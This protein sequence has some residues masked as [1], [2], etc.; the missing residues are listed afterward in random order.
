M[1]LS[2]EWQRRISRIESRNAIMDLIPQ[3]SRVIDEHDLEGI[4]SLFTPEG[5]LRNAGRQMDARGHEGIRALYRQVFTMLGPSFH[6]SHN[7]LIRFDEKD[8]DRATGS[9]T[10]HSET[11]RKGAQYLAA[12]R[13]DDEYR[14]IE[15]RWLFQGRQLNFLYFCTM[16]ELRTILGE[17]KRITVYD[18]PALDGDWPETGEAWRRFSGAS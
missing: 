9:V 15:G 4:V 7:H 12:I 6:Y 11:F 3:Y 2:P 13:Y 17:Q 5:Y 8:E 1:T 16:D 10:G 14:R 18:G